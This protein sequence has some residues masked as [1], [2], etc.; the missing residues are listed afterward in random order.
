MKIYIGFDDT[1]SLESDYG[2]G[3]LVRWFADQLPAGWRSWGVLRQQ[4]LVDDA[5]P[6]T[7]H[8]SAACLVIEACD[9][10]GLLD[11]LIHRAARHLE[12]HAVPGSDPG[13]C[14]AADSDAVLPA[15]FEFGLRCTHTVVTR[16]QARQAC[17]R[18]HLSGHGGNHDG[19]IGA[20]A[21]VGL[22]AAGW[23]GRFIDFGELRRLPAELR[24]AELTRMGIR[25]VAMDR[26]ASVPKPGDLVRTQGWLRPR[27]LGG[28]PALPVIAQE[29]GVW[30]SPG[31]RRGRHSP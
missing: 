17:G 19:V 27:L 6:Y 22:T 4:L 18:A 1:D 16:E 29:P 13:L 30:L 28:H 15:L 14:V 5:V 11:D 23:Y 31:A 8:N 26:D 9:G 21:A 25:V 2:T 12:R 10:G 3:R 24:V 7:S 20:A